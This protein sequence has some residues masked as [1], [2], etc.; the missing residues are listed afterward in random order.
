MGSTSTTRTANSAQSY[1]E[2]FPKGQ[3]GSKTPTTGPKIHCFINDAVP[4][5]CKEETDSTTDRTQETE[6]G[7]A[8]LW[9]AASDP[10]LI[11]RQCNA[12]RGC[13]QARSQGRINSIDVKVDKV[14]PRKSSGHG[15]NLDTGGYTFQGF[16]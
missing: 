2:V 11:L 9:F 4:L 6:S 5:A 15:L 7:G 13:A 12:N 1:Q 10:G 3:T 8:S 16:G 14:Y